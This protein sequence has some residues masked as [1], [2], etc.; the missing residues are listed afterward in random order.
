MWYRSSIWKLKL[1]IVRIISVIVYA[2]VTMTRRRRANFCIDKVLLFIF[3]NIKHSFTVL[4]LQ[5]LISFLSISIRM[6]NVSYIISVCF[7]STFK[8][9][10]HL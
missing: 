6:F 4:F 2:Y 1:L 8:V 10:K 3:F 5:I 7:H 9:S